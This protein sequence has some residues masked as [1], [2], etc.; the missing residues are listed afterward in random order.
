MFCQ[1]WKADKKSNILYILFSLINNQL[2]YIFNFWMCTRYNLR[3]RSVLSR[4]MVFTLNHVS[5]IS[6]NCFWGAEWLTSLASIDLVPTSCRRFK[7][8]QGLWIPNTPVT[9]SH[10]WLIGSYFSQIMEW[11]DDNVF[12]TDI[13]YWSPVFHLSTAIGER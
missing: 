3:H 10:R 8:Q 6:C 11:T 5:S 1:T 7:S 4:N 9:Q 2:L 13:T 12:I